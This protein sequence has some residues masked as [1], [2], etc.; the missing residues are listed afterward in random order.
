MGLLDKFKPKKEIAKFEGLDTD[1]P[2][3]K[4]FTL[5]Q[6]EQLNNF[7][8]GL[9]KAFEEYNDVCHKA[10]EKFDDA[11]LT[12]KSWENRWMP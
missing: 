2:F 7:S 9:L 11:S 10:Y 5:L 12:K 8:R 6:G 1:S 3:Y 4:P